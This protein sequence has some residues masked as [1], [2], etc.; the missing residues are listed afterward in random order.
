MGPHSK[1]AARLGNM[2]PTDLMEA[3]TEPRHHSMAAVTAAVRLEVASTA[4][5]AAVA[6]T[7]V[8]EAGAA[9]SMAVVAADPSVVEAAAML[10]V[11]AVEAEAVVAITNPIS[12]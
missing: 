3:F 9:A 4:H 10:G 8:A 1:A 12:V 5:R 2:L 7:A 6:S 11:V